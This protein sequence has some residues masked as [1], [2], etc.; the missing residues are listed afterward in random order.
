MTTADAYEARDLSR[1]ADLHF[2]LRGPT[3]PRFVRDLLCVSV[4]PYA[5]YVV[6]V[7]GEPQLIQGNSLPWLMQDL[8]PLLDGTRS[9]TDL[10]RSFPHIAASDVRDALLLLH[11]HGMLEEAEAEECERLPN[12][13]PPDSQ[14]FV[15]RYLRRTG[16][17]RSGREAQWTLESARVCITGDG[18]LSLA[19]A[20]SLHDLGVASVKVAS[21]AG[22][23]PVERADLVVMFAAAHALEKAARRCIA[24][25]VPLLA[26]NPDALT[27]GP[28]TI[29]HASA[30]YMCLTL[31]LDSLQPVG[32]SLSPA[33]W[34]LWQRALVSRVAQH[35]VA[36]ATGVIP[37][38]PVEHVEVWRPLESDTI[39]H[40]FIAKLPNCP[41]CGTDAPPRTLTLPSGHEESR[42]RLFHSTTVVQPW[43]LKQPAGMQQHITPHVQR[44]QR[45]IVAGPSA[46]TTSNIAYCGSRASTPPVLARRAGV[47]LSHAPAPVT[48]TV[49]DVSV[50]GALLF[51]SFGGRIE[52][53]NGDAVTLRLHTASAGNLASAEAFVVC[54][55]VEGV[56]PG[57]Y[58]YLCATNELQHV[59]P[60][61]VATV[62]SDA[63]R[64]EAS[65]ALAPR[66]QA[67]AALLVIVSSVARACAKY[68]GR[69]Y[70]YA[71]LDAGVMTHRVELVA[72]EL[73]L[74]ATPFW[75]FDDAALAAALGVDGID[76]CPHLLIALEASNDSGASS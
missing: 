9:V 18:K 66:A 71:L 63:V 56:S 64:S 26:V 53:R 43:H 67:A 48:G 46:G 58:R 25:R 44:L 1:L 31:Q 74:S 15:S 35:V 24:A 72:Q 21:D 10:E 50:L 29:P 42:A 22:T 8:V 54:R 49:L 52:R 12:S 60:A 19:L 70:T 4:G 20:S 32:T 51:Y 55:R 45:A 5:M 30:C 3:H 2:E 69:G 7:G 28:L 6:A 40:R 68:F 17:R 23:V 34:Q 37:A 76:L 13:A 62:F 16:R 38:L 59:G 11:M 73:G 14:I 61:S 47:A 33:L 36:F 57:V 75:Q 27:I 39:L 41:L 65:L